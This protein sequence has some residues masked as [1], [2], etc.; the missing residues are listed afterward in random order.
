[1]FTIILATPAF[2]VLLPPLLWIYM[3]WVLQAAT[4]SMVVENRCMHR[5]LG[6]S[7]FPERLAPLKSCSQAGF[8]NSDCS[9]KRVFNQL[10]AEVNGK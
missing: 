9:F 10:Q 4:F 3:R 1:M 8:P 6:N 7:F 2:A 5:M